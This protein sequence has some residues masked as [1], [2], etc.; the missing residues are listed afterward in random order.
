M[1]L[2]YPEMAAN[3]FTPLFDNIMKQNLL[4]QN[5]FAFYFTEFPIQESVI[6]FGEDDPDYY[7]GEL[8]WFPV[9]NHYYWQ[10]DFKD[11]SINGK[12]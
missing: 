9:T 2:A 6:I 10:I 11:I 1:G 7:E 3:D 5:T 12:K 8:K 4:K